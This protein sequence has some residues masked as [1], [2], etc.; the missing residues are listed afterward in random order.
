MGRSDSKNLGLEFLKRDLFL[1]T[2]CMNAFHVC[3]YVCMQVCM[4]VCAPRHQFPETAVTH[5]CEPLCVCGTKSGS[6]PREKVRLWNSLC[7]HCADV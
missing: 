7:V 1:F 3:M 4:Y 6:S 5:G 2:I